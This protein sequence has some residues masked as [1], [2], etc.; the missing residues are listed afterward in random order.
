MAEERMVK[1]VYK[2]KPMLRRPLGRP[3]NRW[4]DDL[5]NDMKKLKIKNC[6]QDRKNWKL[7]VEK[8]KTFKEL[9]LSRLKKKKKKKIS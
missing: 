4:E 1:K 9:K 2:W 6:I 5:R 3:K 7:Y 8:A